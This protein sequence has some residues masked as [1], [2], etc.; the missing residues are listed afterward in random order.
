MHQGGH[1]HNNKTFFVECRAINQ[2]IINDLRCPYPLIVIKDTMQV[3][4]GQAG[5]GTSLPKG[6]IIDT[7]SAPEQCS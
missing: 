1:F 2:S 4:A 7:N 5:V 6:A 3:S